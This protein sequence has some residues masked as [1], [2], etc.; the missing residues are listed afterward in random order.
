MARKPL[1]RAKKKLKS[2]KPLLQ[3][4]SCQTFS[5]MPMFING[6]ELVSDNRSSTDFKSPSRS[7]LLTPVLENLSSL[8]RLE[9]PIM[10]TMSLREKLKEEKKARARRSQQILRERELESTR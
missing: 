1:Q 4:D 8:V 5:K 2:Q 10:T 9:E 6:Q 3:S 7:S